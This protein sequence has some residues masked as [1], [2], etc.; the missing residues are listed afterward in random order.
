MG[1]EPYRMLEP[2]AGFPVIAG[3]QMGMQIVIVIAQ[4]CNILRPV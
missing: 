4:I 1:I 3:K 2:F